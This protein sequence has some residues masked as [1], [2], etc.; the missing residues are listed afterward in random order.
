MINVQRV[1]QLS[2]RSDEKRFLVDRLWPRGISKDKLRLDAWLKEVAP[3]D[4]LRKWYHHDLDKWEEFK[5]RYFSEL[6]QKP[7]AWKPLLDAAVQQH[8]IILLYSSKEE[9]RN[10]AVALKI[11]LE[12]KRSD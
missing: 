10:N 8:N 12:S 3:S 4:S 6:D 2:I 7:D 1:Y 5:H 11:Y 9:N